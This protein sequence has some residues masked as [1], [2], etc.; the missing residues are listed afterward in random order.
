MKNR[1]LRSAVLTAATAIALSLAACSNSTQSV[2]EACEIA[3]PQLAALEAELVPRYND[4]DAASKSDRDELIAPILEE[5][6]AM[7]GTV[8]NDEVK[9]VFED[10]SNAMQEMS[11]LWDEFNI[12]S[13]D[14]SNTEAEQ[15]QEEL[16]ALLAQK[17][18]SFM[19]I[20][21]R[22]NTLCTPA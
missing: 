19:L 21:E 22:L 12:E 3:L 16:D 9:S 14:P 1:F 4:Y 10:Y 2:E 6:R 18:E 8:E 5:I 15:K 7:P 17:S 11:D 13:L 20:I